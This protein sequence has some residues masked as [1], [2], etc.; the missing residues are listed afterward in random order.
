MPK[1]I[2]TAKDLPDIWN[3]MAFGREFSRE[4]YFGIDDR[5]SS[6][7]RKKWHADTIPDIEVPPS[8]DENHP[9]MSLKESFHFPIATRDELDA[10]VERVKPFQG[11]EPVKELHSIVGRSTQP[12]GT[13]FIGKDCESQLFLKLLEKGPMALTEEE[14]QTLNDSP[15]FKTHFRYVRDTIFTD[16]LSLQYLNVL[17]DSGLGPAL[18]E[19]YKTSLHMFNSQDNGWKFEAL[20]KNERGNGFPIYTQT[21]VS[22]PGALAYQLVVLEALAPLAASATDEQIANAARNMRKIAEFDHTLLNSYLKSLTPAIISKP[23]RLTRIVDT[24]L[25]F[26]PKK[27]ELSRRLIEDYLK[28][29]Y[30]DE[31][32]NGSRL[33]SKWWHD[34]AIDHFLMAS[35]HYMLKGKRHF[36][37][38]RDWVKTLFENNE[39]DDIKV[40]CSFIGAAYRRHVPPALIEHTQR[41]FLS[42]FYSTLDTSCTQAASDGVAHI[43]AS[44][45]DPA[46]RISFVTDY[47]I[48]SAFLNEQRG[49]G[50]D[51]SRFPHPEPGKKR[52]WIDALSNGY[53]V[54]KDS[55]PDWLEC[56]R[57]LTS[58]PGFSWS[59][60]LYNRCN[61]LLPRKGRALFE[62][63]GGN[64]SVALIDMLRF[65]GFTGS[66]ILGIFEP[67]IE[68]VHSFAE[69]L[70]Q[71]TKITGAIQFGQDITSESW[72]SKVHANLVANVK[73]RYGLQ[74]E[75]AQIAGR[76][77]FSELCRLANI[78]YARDPEKPEEEQ[79]KQEKREHNAISA[80]ATKRIARALKT[81]FPLGRTYDQLDVSGIKN[82]ASAPEMAKYLVWGLISRDPGKVEEAAS[83]YSPEMIVEARVWVEKANLAGKIYFTI[84]PF[85]SRVEGGD[86]EATRQLV[87]R[88]DKLFTTQQ[89][90]DE[91]LDDLL[92]SVKSLLRKDT[93]F[94]RIVFKTQ[95]RTIDDLFLSDFLESCAFKNSSKNSHGGVLYAADRNI[96]LL[97]VVP[98][99]DGRLMIPIGA[100]ILV[101]CTDGNKG[102]RANNGA[103]YLAIDTFEGGKELDRIRGGGWRTRFLE[104]AYAVGRDIGA[105]YAFINFRLVNP[106]EQPRRF[107]Y[108]CKG[109]GLETVDGEQLYLR[110]IGGIGQIRRFGF[111]RHLLDMFSPDG[112]TSF[113]KPEG[114]VHGA[115]VKL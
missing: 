77:S 68:D 79:E 55:F 50:R 6:L 10:L 12:W 29:S 107:V 78:R 92:L 114:Y 3:T 34:S 103:R 102:N 1:I 70:G 72:Y 20:G 65:E 69:L 2:D 111:Y 8:M 13:A 67:L 39:F 113:N 46:E 9:P 26:D 56:I 17:V 60:D 7:Y 24:A 84:S 115:V 25:S 52:E 93:I 15:L 21:R 82:R 31:L 36:N 23:T 63:E 87:Y 99:Y 75:P 22:A 37:E 14:L 64:I 97:H 54:D 112:K 16:A 66:G 73:K 45:E 85:L 28:H 48:A 33:M 101:N 88:L 62:F 11:L 42:R 83:Y 4:N 47:C 44:C 59:K 110:K 71:T 30:G 32:F 53:G 58:Q 91:I 76:L 86:V 98:E 40:E 81:P 51:T 57:K 27:N 41:D 100:G 90:V 80:L 18:E 95:D 108:H 19:I 74:A 61:A 49:Y 109:L 38:F 96:A 89:K 35:P 94:D 104:S 105:D 5:I 106:N 43:L